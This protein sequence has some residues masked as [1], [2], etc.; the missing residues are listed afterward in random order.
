[1]NEADYFSEDELAAAPGM[2]LPEQEARAQA[3]QLRGP[4]PDAGRQ[5]IHLADTIIDLPC[6]VSDDCARRV[7]DLRGTS[8]DDP[9][10]ARERLRTILEAVA[11]TRAA[12]G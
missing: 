4:G 8:E 2:L 1:M 3:Q 12:G 11:A 5:R 10:A 6:L 7:R 9:V